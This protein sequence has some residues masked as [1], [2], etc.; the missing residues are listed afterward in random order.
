MEWG[1][2]RG[3][4][5]EEREEAVCFLIPVCSEETKEPELTLLSSLPVESNPQN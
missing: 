5:T 1:T 4:G 2:K 3:S